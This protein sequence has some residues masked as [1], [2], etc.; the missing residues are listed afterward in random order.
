MKTTGSFLACAVAVGLLLAG[1]TAPV[2]SAVIDGTGEGP[3]DGP[4]YQTMRSLAHYLDETAQGLLE[5]A[6]DTV[7]HGR[8]SEARFLS[9]IRS[10]AR[11]ARDFRS[12]VDG[13]RQ[14]P[15]DVSARQAALAEVARAVNER[16]RSAGA[17]ERTYLEWNAVTDVLHRMELLLAG[18]DVKVPPTYVVPSLSGARLEQFRQLA[19]AL[20]GSATLAHT[21]AQQELGSY[22]HRGRQFL[23]EL[24]YFA[25]LSRDLHARADAG[26]VRPKGMGP[27]VDD[28]LKEARDADRRMRDANVFKEVWDQSGRTIAILQQMANLVRS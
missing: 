4:R 12:A 11:S 16:L 27:I 3:L 14:A 18:G 7:L 8:S 2:A 13:Y 5:G 10:F 15:F 6:S 26:D 21:R 1:F 17:L 20:D 19:G 28:L 25:A 23:G 22:Q 9:P 24:H